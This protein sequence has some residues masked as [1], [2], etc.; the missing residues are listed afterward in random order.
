MYVNI[1]LA[2]MAVGFAAVAIYRGLKHRGGFIIYLL[3][4]ILLGVFLAV[5]VESIELAG[6]K[7]QIRGSRLQ[8]VTISIKSL[9][10]DLSPDDLSVLL[11]PAQNEGK[12]EST[13]QGVT[14]SFEGVPEGLYDIVVADVKGHRFLREGRLV[15]RT[16]NELE[17]IERFPLGASVRGVA[18]PFGGEEG[19]VLPVVI[20]KQFTWTDGDGNFRVSGLNPDSRYEL[21][22]LGNEI[23]SGQVEMSGYEKT[24]DA[25]IYAPEPVQVARICEAMEIISGTGSDADT[26]LCTDRDNDRY[27]ADIKKLWFYTR[28]RATPPTEIVHRWSYGND[29]FDVPLSI[30]SQSFRTRSSREIA[31]KTGQWTVAVLSHDKGGCPGDQVLSGWLAVIRGETAGWDNIRFFEPDSRHL[32][33]PRVADGQLDRFPDCRPIPALESSTRLVSRFYCRAPAE[34]WRRPG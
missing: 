20:G 16:H 3:G 6:M 10:K 5:P 34:R 25:P 14:Y 24:L 23:S 1:L 27:P 33:P 4:A 17:P 31:G 26:W 8:D 7:I 28:I 12:A 29:S 19:S 22:I 18:R 11:V 15:V 32:V 13:E 30:E 21:K 2:A 9:A